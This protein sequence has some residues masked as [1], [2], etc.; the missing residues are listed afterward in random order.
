MTTRHYPYII[1]DNV[2]SPLG[3]TTA[4]NFEAVRAGRSS[5]ARYAGRSKRPQVGASAGMDAF[6]ASRFSDDQRQALMVEG[7]TRFESLVYHSVSEAL[8][9]CT[10][11]VASRRTL[12]VIST[13]KANVE[14]LSSPDYE[15]LQPAESAKRI[16]SRL[17]VTTPPLVVCNACISGVAALVTAQRLLMAGLYDTIIVTGCDIISHFIVSGFQSLKALSPEPCRPF[18]IDRIG[19]NLGEAAATI[20]LTNGEGLMVNGEGLMV[21]GEGLMVNGYWLLVSDQWSMVNG[22]WSMASGAI[23]NDAYHTSSPSPK[24]DGCA[25]AIRYVI[26]GTDPRSLSAV[27]AHGTATLFNDQMES[28]ALAATGLSQTPTNSLK[29]YFGHTLGAS[30]ILETIITMHS[31]ASGELPATRGFSE[32]GVSGKMTLSA[33]PMAVSGHSFVK[34]ISGFGGCN[35][36]LYCTNTPPTPSPTEN[37]APTTLRIMH[38][39]EITPSRVTIDGRECPIEGEGADILTWI[40]KNHIGSYPKFYKMDRLS[41]LGF[42]ASELLLAQEDPRKGPC[43]DRAV[44]LFNHSSSVCADRAFAQTIVPGEDYYPSPSLFVGTLPNIVCGEIA[45]RHGYHSE[46]SFYIMSEKDESM[47]NKV[48]QSTFL[49]KTVHSMVTGWVDYQDNE[50][51]EAKV[52]IIEH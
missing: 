4:A 8:T 31:V 25:S 3:S 43:T 42:V 18:D 41:Q 48:V 40:Y 51:F 23:R 52:M 32:S 30:G 2:L 36:A 37:V 38:S 20:I 34:V 49:D 7:L 5:L 28:V 9:H 35:A 47:I 26:D 13:T 1:A 17:G 44:V 15:R 22:Q 39:V 19:M 50:N 10:I 33:S 14:H 45:I 11:D 27:N 21:N 24:G 16:A 6:V 46:T 12:L 29:G